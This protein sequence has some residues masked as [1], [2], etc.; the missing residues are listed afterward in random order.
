MRRT[1]LILI[2]LILGTGLLPAQ[3]YDRTL[4]FHFDDR[5]IV[6]PKFGLRVE[7]LPI[8]E[9]LGAEAK[10]SPAAGT[11]GVL[12]GEHVIQFAIDH[13]VL[14]VD[15]ELQEARETPIASPGG[16]A[17]SLSYLERWLL[18][19]LGF[20]LEPI[21][22]G[23][24]IARGA[25]F[26]EAVVVR[27]VAADFGATTTLVLSL[28]HPAQ[29]TVEETEPGSLHHPFRR[30]HPSAGQQRALPIAAS[31]LAD[32]YGPDDPHQPGPRHWSDLVASAG[33][34]TQDH[35]RA[36]TGASHA[37]PGTGPRTGGTPNRASAGGD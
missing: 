15:G 11:Y 13:K 20:H 4:E 35:D 2:A 34:P 16:V 6:V 7:A 21:P 8:V 28:N 14:L 12:Y 26:A 18:S 36:R 5:A 32:Q 25:R 31:A 23:Y 37:D 22:R 9:L 3:D 19:P 24:R 27:P 10:Y 1:Q 17:V 30:R 33:D 29:V